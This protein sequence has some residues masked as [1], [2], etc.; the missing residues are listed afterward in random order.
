MA[1]PSKPLTCS[2]LWLLCLQYVA[3][4]SHLG[5]RRVNDT[6]L[7]PARNFLI[8]FVRNTAEN[9]QEGKHLFASNQNSTRQK[10]KTHV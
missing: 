1:T 4:T 7:A 2:K 8:N 6:A 10:L 5:S 3:V 9:S